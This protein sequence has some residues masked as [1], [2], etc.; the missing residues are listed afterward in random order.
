MLS[1]LAHCLP[2]AI[3]EIAMRSPA[4]QGLQSQSAAARKK[5]CTVRLVNLSSQPVKDRFTNA[6]RSR[7]QARGSTKIELTATPGTADNAQAVF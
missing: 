6:V 7:A 2:V 3:H 5:V 4:G 1:N